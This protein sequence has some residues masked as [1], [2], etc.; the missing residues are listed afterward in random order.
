MKQIKKNAFTLIELL[1]VIIIL[2]IVA[3]IAT[4]IILDV[5]DDARKSAGLSESNMI[6]SGINNYCAT[7]EIKI[8]M[9]SSYT[10]VCT[11]SMTKED[12]PTMVN[13]GNA[14]ILEIEYSDK[15]TWLKV[16]SN[17]KIYSLQDNAMVEGD[18][19]KPE[20]AYSVG[21]LLKVQVSDSETQNIYVLEVNGDEIVG[22]L[23]RNLPG[24]PVAW[25]NMEDYNSAGG[26]TMTTANRNSY[27]VRFNIEEAGNLLYAFSRLINKKPRYGEAY[28]LA[29]I[30]FAQYVKADIDYAKNFVIDERNSLVFHAGLGVAVPYGN[31][32]SLPFEKLYFSGGANS[33]RGW[34]VRSLGPGSYRGD[35]NTI[36][37]VN[38]TGDIKL[39]LNLEYRTFLFWKLNGA[40]FIDAG[41][42]W[43][44][45]NQGIQSE[46]VFKFNRFYKQLAVSYGLGIRFDLDFLILRFDGGMKAVNPMYTGR[47]RY[48]IISPDFK[49]DFAF[50]FAVGY[51]F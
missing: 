33:V 29:N 7:E 41:N 5:V 22:I 30:D 44:I 46:G 28:Q 21:N 25:I 14:E 15:L 40:A 45:R 35:G 19:D 32:K 10:A 43:N 12:V 34:R 38:H 1:A 17:G 2:A 9:N 23:D 18:L 47:D 27:S 31:S 4:P 39:D 49:R 48:P 26:N 37:Y 6:L 36:D 20:V 50:H 42:V 8:Q 3:L 13:L 24:G 11:S 16:K 51:P